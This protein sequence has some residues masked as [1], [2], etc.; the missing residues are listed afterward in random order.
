MYTGTLG[1][2]FFRRRISSL[3]M[4]D[5]TGLPPGLLARMT[6]PRVLLSSKAACRP[7]S[8]LPVSSLSLSMAPSSDTTAVCGLPTAAVLLRLSKSANIRPTKA[9]N[10]PS[11]ARRKK[12]FQRRALRCSFRLALASFSISLRSQLCS[13]STRCPRLRFC[14]GVG[15]IVY[16]PIAFF[17]RQPLQAA[18]AARAGHAQ[19]AVGAVQRAVQAADQVQAAA[20]EKPAV[21]PVQLG[22][23]VAAAGQVG[24]HHALVAYG[25]GGGLFA[26]PVQGKEHTL[27]AVGQFVGAGDQLPCI[28]HCCNSG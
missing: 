2:S 5:S 7:S 13:C 8:I 21:L 18:A 15:Q 23:D 16:M 20:I 25:K 4:P 19:A 28:S 22:G 11:Q 6:M 14:M 1:C 26:M 9:T 17:Y 27:D 3:A 24:V 10:A 12:I